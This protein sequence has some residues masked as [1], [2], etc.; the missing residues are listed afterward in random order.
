MSAGKRQKFPADFG[1]RTSKMQHT[2]ATSS[3]S[4]PFPILQIQPNQEKHAQY[5][6]GFG[7]PESRS[8]R[9]LQT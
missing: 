4:L 5:V 7:V 3:L 1:G 2:R 9:L 6:R 8:G